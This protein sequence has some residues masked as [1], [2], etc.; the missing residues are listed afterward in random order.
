MNSAALK[1]VKILANGSGF[2]EGS[3]TAISEDIVSMMAAVS[4]KLNPSPT[5]K[6]NIST[7]DEPNPKYAKSL[8]TFIHHFKATD[9]SDAAIFKVGDTKEWKG[10][11]WYFL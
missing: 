3:S 1:Y 2:F 10:D 5:S 4:K 11:T 7:S 6:N 9:A 8:P